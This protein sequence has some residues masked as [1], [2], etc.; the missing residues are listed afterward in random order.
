MTKRES[1]KEIRR[2]F[3]DFAAHIGCG[4]CGARGIRDEA[5]NRIGKLLRMKK[6]PDGSGYDYRRYRTK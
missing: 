2:A 5:L 6:Y 3:A 1:L 4:C